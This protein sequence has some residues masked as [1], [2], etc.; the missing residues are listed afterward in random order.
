MSKVEPKESPVKLDPI[1]VDFPRVTLRE[2][3]SRPVVVHEEEPKP[4]AGPPRKER[5]KEEAAVAQQAELNR[6]AELARSIEAEYSA[7]MKQEATSRPE[8]EQRRLP[9]PEPVIVAPVDL[10]VVLEEE[11]VEPGTKRSS[12][13]ICTFAE[14]DFVYVHAVS[15]I[16]EG[17]AHATEP[18]TLEEKGIDGHAFAFVFD[19][20]GL[21][22]FLSKIN[23]NEM[24]ISKAMVLLLNKQE[25]L[26]LQGV[27]E[28]VLNDLR[29]HGMLLPVEFGTVVR[30]KEQLCDIVDINKDDLDDAL[31]DLD[32]TTWWTVTAFVLDAT[33]AG[34]VGTDVKTVG[35]DR[36]R[37]RASYTSAAQSKKFD[38]KVLERILQRE[39]KLAEAIH[40]GLCSVAEK[41]DLDT[42]VGLGSGSSEDWKL[43]LKGAY[44]IPKKEI[45]KFNRAVTDL[46]YHHMQYEL[47]LTLTGNKDCISLRRK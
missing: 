39:K 25:S 42:I 28:S 14:N 24:S 46:Q 16:P 19:Y 34:I 11:S 44:F 33:I 38:I 35:R 13:S 26:E 27:H 3:L 36:Q 23:P 8:P 43:I 30:G 22:F 20:Q 6:L 2:E 21:R 29:A 15:R 17:E 9:E 40:D 37:D 10:P 1:K 18:F 5:S 31:D 47:M 41:S 32:K 12:R 7:R 4:I 45:A